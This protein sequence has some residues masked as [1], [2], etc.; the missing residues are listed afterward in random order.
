MQK[1]PSLE[2]PVFGREKQVRH[3]LED[4]TARHDTAL[5][6]VA[7]IGKT[8]MAREIATSGAKEQ[9]FTR[10]SLVDVEKGAAVARADS[11]QTHESTVEILVGGMANVLGMKDPFFVRDLTAKLR[12]LA[13]APATH[14]ILFI[15]DHAQALRREE[16][17]W[18]EKVI[19]SLPKHCYV[20]VLSR[21]HLKTDLREIGFSALTEDDVNAWMDF[22]ANRNADLGR[23]LAANGVRQQIFSLSK[24]FPLAIVRLLSFLAQKPRPVSA[25]DPQVLLSRMSGIVADVFEGLP[26][27]DDDFKV[28]RILTS[29][30]TAVDCGALKRATGLEE[31]A[32][33]LV[34]ER[35]TEWCLAE[36]RL[37]GEIEISP[38][39]R[40]ALE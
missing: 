14:K 8:M 24:G 39:A 33:S 22:V 11:L 40:L 35:L 17:P 4:L 37:S 3:A 28:L 9:L 34:T 36:E 30:D 16:V 23:L 10:I 21:R 20:L 38:F 12:M 6:G 15:V 25:L 26:L 7:G 29:F 1:Q 31:E 27:S 32:L 13:Y 18:L 2:S 19:Q 5:I